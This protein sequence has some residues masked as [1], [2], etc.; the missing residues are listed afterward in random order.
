VPLFDVE[1]VA[2]EARL[3]KLPFNGGEG[4][5]AKDDVGGRTVELEVRLRE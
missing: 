5:P 4:W 2:L 1:E 3:A